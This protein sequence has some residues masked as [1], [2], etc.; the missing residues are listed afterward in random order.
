MRVQDE[1]QDLTNAAQQIGVQRS[2]AVGRM[3]LLRWLRCQAGQGTVN[4]G[5]VAV[6]M[7]CLVWSM[8]LLSG[9]DLKPGLSSLVHA[10]DPLRDRVAGLS[11]HLPV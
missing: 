2:D 9:I 7:L 8:A 5:F 4:M 6:T 1:V 3:P 10:T 11:D